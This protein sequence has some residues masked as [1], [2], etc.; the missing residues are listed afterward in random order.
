MTFSPLAMIEMPF[1]AQ[2]LIFDEI[3]STNEEAL[4]RIKAEEAEDGLWIMASS[5]TRGRG[6]RGREWISS[7][8]NFFASVLVELQVPL[9]QAPALSFVAALAAGDCIKEI[10]GERA[11]VSFKW[12]NDVLVD[13][14][15]AAGILIEAET[16]PKSGQNWAV[17]GIGINTASAPD[18]V[19]FPATALSDHVSYT[20]SNNNVLDLLSKAWREHLHAL[21][22]GGFKVIRARWLETAQGLGSEICVKL[23]DR[24]QRGV[25]A[26][27]GRGGELL[28]QL[29]DGHELKILAGDVT[30]LNL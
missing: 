5:Q 19:R 25:F 11:G 21:N 13:G 30:E 18:Q 1:G 12:P 27:L 14:H 28:L 3:D 22:R 17:V 15:K 23:G 2:A 8:G 16:N 10:V 6:R 4:R 20:I 9:A 26:G 29:A 7:K 24:E